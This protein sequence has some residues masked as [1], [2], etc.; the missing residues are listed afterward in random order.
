[1]SKNRRDF[2]KNAC[3]PILFGTLGIPLVNSCSKESS[4]VT[5]L[6]ST[7]SEP[8]SIELNMN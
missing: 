3:A 6:P 8:F 2:L 7:P 5:T 1:M 4:S